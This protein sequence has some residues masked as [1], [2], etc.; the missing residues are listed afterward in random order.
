M[1]MVLKEMPVEGVDWIN[2]F[3]YRKK[4]QAQQALHQWGSGPQIR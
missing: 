2:L 1:K 3:R 4:Q